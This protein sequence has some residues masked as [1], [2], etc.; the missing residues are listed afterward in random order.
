PLKSSTFFPYTTLFRS[1]DPAFAGE[2]AVILDHGMRRMIEEQVDEF[3]YITLTNESY[4]QP[5]MP[6]GIEKQIVQGMY[7][8]RREVC[9][10]EGRSEE[11]TSELQ[12]RENLV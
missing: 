11:H 4:A 3:Y 8:Y 5:S 7:C 6:E 9:A 10:A 1:Y 2:L 12:S